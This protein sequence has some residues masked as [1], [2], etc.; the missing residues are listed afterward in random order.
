MYILYTHIHIYVLFNINIHIHILCMYIHA[1]L[2]IMYFHFLFKC[3][4]GDTLFLNKRHKKRKLYLAW[5]P[6][7]T[8]IKSTVYCLGG[9]SLTIT[10]V[11]IVVRHYGQFTCSPD[12]QFVNQ[13]IWINF[14]CFCLR[15]LNSWF[16]VYKTDLAFILSLQYINYKFFKITVHI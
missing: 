14:I 12:I 6:E 7:L 16:Y 10:I 3:N 11:T 4:A 2:C 13:S 9:I 5:F 15:C 1:H 8:Q